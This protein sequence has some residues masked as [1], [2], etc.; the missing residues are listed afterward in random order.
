MATIRKKGPRQWHVQVRRR[1]YPRQTATFETRAKADEWAAKV[2]SEMRSG[3][4]RDL[5]AAERMTMAEAFAKYRDE[6]ATEHKGAS[7][8]RLRLNRFIQDKISGY[9]LATCS[10]EVVGDYIKRRLEEVSSG[11]VRRE[12]DLLSQVFT[13]AIMDWHIPLPENPVH[14]VRRPAPSRQRDR[15]LKRHE[16]EA[17]AST[18]TGGGRSENGTFSKGTRN[19][20]IQP[21]FELSIETA[22]RR[23]ELLRA[24]WSDVRLQERHIF[25]S[26]SKNGLPRRIMLN[27][28]AVAVLERLW[29]M[30]QARVNEAGEAGKPYADERVFKVSDNAVKKAWARARASAEVPDIRWH[31]LRHEGTSRAAAKLS[32]VLELAAFTGHKDLRSVQRYYQPD[33]VDIAA[34]LDA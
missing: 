32:N 10:R 11:T 2:E 29:G 22:A 4:F 30:H 6:V 3:T 8:E 23:S 34:K 26:D 14:H 21:L 5:G 18:L 17:I 15:R 24:T 19:P 31:D 25:L 33:S 16:E 12:I 9:S 7:V 20:W 28:K 27:A 1:G 13:S